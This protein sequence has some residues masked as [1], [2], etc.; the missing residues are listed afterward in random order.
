MEVCALLIL[1]AKSGHP[2]ADA[3]RYTHSSG[4]AGGSFYFEEATNTTCSSVVFLDSNLTKTVMN[5]NEL[6]ATHIQELLRYFIF[7]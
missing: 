4:D 3:P 2:T 7:I 5:I 6:N 1:T